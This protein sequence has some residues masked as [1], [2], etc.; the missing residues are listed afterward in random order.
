MQTE[1]ASFYLLEVSTASG[2][3]FT[4]PQSYFGK[5][6]THFF[7]IYRDGVASA[8][9]PYDELQELG[10]YLAQKASDIEYAKK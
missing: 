3:Y 7:V 4:A 6:L 10:E 2:V 9:L 1:A 5:S 8:R